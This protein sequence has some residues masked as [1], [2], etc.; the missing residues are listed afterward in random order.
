MK[1]DLDRRRFLK[2]AGTSMG[3]GALYTVWPSLGLSL[4]HI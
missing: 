2:I 1:K 4:I 3:V